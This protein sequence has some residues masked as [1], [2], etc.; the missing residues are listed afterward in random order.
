MSY[1]KDTVEF[2]GYLN[3]GKPFTIDDIDLQYN[4]DYNFNESVIA[5]YLDYMVDAKILE[6]FK[7]TTTFGTQTYYL[8]VDD[9]PFYSFLTIK[10]LKKLNNDRYRLNYIRRMK[11]I[12][13]K[14]KSSLK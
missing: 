11:I 13:L 12:M 1:F 14:Y 7:T 6:A 2:V 10:S 5:R 8:K 4:Y 9:Y 3:I